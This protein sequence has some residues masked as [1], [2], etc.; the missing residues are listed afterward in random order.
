MPDEFVM[1][2]FGVGNSPILH[3]QMSL[4]QV[5]PRCLLLYSVMRSRFTSILCVQQKCAT[6][7]E[8]IFSTSPSFLGGPRYLFGEKNEFTLDVDTKTSQ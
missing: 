2:C 6:R 4:K 3:F 5:S 7:N 1:N 8:L